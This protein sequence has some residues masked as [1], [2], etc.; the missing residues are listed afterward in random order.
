MDDNDLHAIYTTT[1]SFD[2]TK[3]NY[4][5]SVEDNQVTGTQDKVVISGKI[6]NVGFCSGIIAKSPIL[7][8]NFDTLFDSGTIIGVSVGG[9]VGL[10]FTIFSMVMV[11]IKMRAKEESINAGDG[12]R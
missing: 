5:I 11:R 8:V 12:K 2:H 7:C 10:V 9:I 4:T 6:S 3:L 1:I